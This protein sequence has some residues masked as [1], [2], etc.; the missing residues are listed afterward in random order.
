MKVSKD[1]IENMNAVDNIL[2][3]WRYIEEEG[4]YAYNAKLLANHIKDNYSMSLATD[5]NKKSNDKINI[6]EEKNNKQL[7]TMKEIK[8]D[9]N[10]F[11]PQVIEPYSEHNNIPT[12]KKEK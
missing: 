4:P 1:F 6:E 3:D 11:Y 7:N 8:N 2:G 12:E 10:I 9:L 5:R